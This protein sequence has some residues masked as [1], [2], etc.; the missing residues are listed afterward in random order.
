[1]NPNSGRPQNSSAF[2][3]EAESVNSVSFDSVFRVFSFLLLL[4]STLEVSHSSSQQ[5]CTC[6]WLL[7]VF[8]HKETEGP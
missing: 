3:R 2:L 4:V 5:S 6:R 1:M 8:A 7:L